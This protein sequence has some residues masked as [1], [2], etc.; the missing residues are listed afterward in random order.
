ATVSVAPGET[1]KFIV[2]VDVTKL[3]PGEN[4]VEIRA[5]NDFVEGSG[6]VIVSFAAGESEFQPIPVI[7]AVKNDADEPLEDVTGSVTGIPS[8][9]VVMKGEPITVPAHGEAN[10]TLFIKPATNEDAYPVLTVKS[11]DRV[12]QT[13]KLPPIKAK[14]SGLSGFFTAFG[15]NT[16]AAI[17]ALIVV[18]FVVALMASRARMADER[19]EH[20][21]RLE[22]VRAAVRS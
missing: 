20:L 2:L 17:A 16:T 13:V 14:S 18:A 9:W 7:V 6:K 1:K 22:S 15:S 11:G 19:E 4:P 12:L 10:L 3:V 8:S 5:E 21:K